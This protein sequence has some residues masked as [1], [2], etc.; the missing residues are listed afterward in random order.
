MVAPKRVV[1]AGCYNDGWQELI[2]P[3]AFSHPAKYARGLIHRLYRHLLERGYVRAGDTIL[4][5]FGGVALGALDALTYGLRWV[6]CELEP[7]FVALG[8]QNLA[9]WRQ[10]YGFTGGTL[11]QG[12]SRQ[13]RA[14]LSHTSCCPHCGTIGQQLGQH[15]GEA[16]AK[17]QSETSR[18]EYSEGNVRRKTDD[19][20]TNST[21]P[22]SIRALYTA[23]DAHIP[24]QGQALY[25]EGQ[26]PVY[27]RENCRESPLSQN[28]ASRAMRD[29]S[30]S[31]AS[32]C[33]S[34]QLR[35]LRQ[36]AAEPTDTLPQLPHELTQKTVLGVNQEGRNAETEYSTSRVDQRAITAPGQL[37][38]LPPGD[39]AAVLSSRVYP[40]CVHDGN[41]IDHT[42][43]T[44]NTPGPHTQAKAEG[45][46]TT[47]GN[48]G[49]LP[50]GAVVSPPPYAGNL[51]HDY[52]VTDEGGRDRDVRRGK[53]QGLGCFR[54]SET[55]GQTPGNLGA[56][57][58]G[59]VVSSPPYESSQQVD[60]RTKKP[61]ALSSTWEKR[62]GT[63]SDGASPG[64]LAN[65]PLTFWS[66]ASQIMA[67]VAA[68]L[69]LGAVACWVVKGYVSKG[70]LV[71][72]PAQ[73]QT[74][75]EAH[76]FVLLEEIHASLVEDH[77]IQEALF[78]AA[79][80]VTTERKSFFR[81]LHERKP[82]A[83]RIDH[84]TVLILRKEA[85][86]P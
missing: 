75:C 43:L 18:R 35:S 80:Q 59:A 77:G 47:P 74:L 41:G 33:P 16:Y 17:I 53:R 44:G 3:T 21:S 29:V 45:Y 54:D 81:R 24:D 57:P 27:D 11:L 38:T 55:Y 19:T 1:W 51:Q 15:G 66:A 28:K 70:K 69:P 20:S 78:G 49:A 46:G 56:L 50:P 62:F 31:N 71:D 4:D 58:M 61:S 25:R 5:P 76:G 23:L 9:L 83:V 48:L 42:K 32:L 39:I 82:G 7:H 2:V 26:P 22:G 40:G 14:V 8:Q 84:E 67:E 73:W 79:E 30:I 64:Q 37:G 52:R 6:G 63:I 85:L 72:F 10:R 34:C 60:N 36:Q 68:V 12:D 65:E 86:T 13:L